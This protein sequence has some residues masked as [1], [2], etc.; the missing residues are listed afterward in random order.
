MGDYSTRVKLP[1]KR[2]DE[3]VDLAHDFNIMAEKTQSLIHSQKRLLRDI[4]HELRSPL[5][6]QNV[7]LELARKQSKGGEAQLSRIALE[8]KKINALIDQLLTL[9][10]L[11]SNL[12]QAK[13]PVDLKQLIDEIIIDVDFELGNKKGKVKLNKFDNIYIL[14]SA[15]MLKRALENVIRNALYYTA[16]KKGITIELTVKNESVIILVQDYGPGVPD[17]YLEQIFKPFFRV[18]ESRKR[19]DGGAGIGLAIARQAVIHHGGQ[20]K[21]WNIDGAKTGLQIEICLPVLKGNET[22]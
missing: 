11:E 13:E 6:R 4:S 19:D 17:K 3:I 5:T 7:A 20:I 16:P 18:D 22:H 14:G 8:S 21:A 2:G 10:R 15:E 9:T 12:E 1:G